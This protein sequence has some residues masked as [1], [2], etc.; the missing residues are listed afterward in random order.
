MRE[1]AGCGAA[2]SF[3]RVHLST[4]YAQEV[5]SFGQDD[6]KSHIRRVCTAFVG[7]ALNGVELRECELEFERRQG[8]SGPWFN[9]H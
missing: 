4:H 7:P 6:R 3:C 5:A 9:M 2:D 1:F 8:S